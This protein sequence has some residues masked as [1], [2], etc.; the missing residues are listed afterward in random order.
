MPDREIQPGDWVEFVDVDRTRWG[1]WR[2]LDVGDTQA[3]VNIDDT[4][5][6]EIPLSKLR[7]TQMP[8]AR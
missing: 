5:T 7:R 3:K 1:P 8:Q 6:D 2:V 4:M